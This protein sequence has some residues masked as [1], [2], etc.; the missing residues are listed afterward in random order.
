ML[1]VIGVYWWYQNDDLCLPLFK[2]PP[3]AIPPFWHAIFTIIVNGG[4]SILNINLFSDAASRNVKSFLIHKEQQINGI[5]K[6]MKQMQ[7]SEKAG[8]L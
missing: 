7:E 1:H 2:V 3:K 8:A 6:S 4:V 5:I